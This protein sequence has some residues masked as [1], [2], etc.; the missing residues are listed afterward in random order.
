MQLYD[1]LADWFHL[2]TPPD[3]YGEEAAHYLALVRSV[4]PD[5]HTLLELGSGGGNN[6]SHLKRELACTLSDVSPRMLAVSAALNPECEHVTGDMRVLRLGRTFDAVLLHDAVMYLTSED[7]LRAAMG[8]AYAHTRPGGVA[9]FV[10]DCTL[11][12]FIG[13]DVSTGGR[14][15]PDGRQ[16]RFLEWSHDP[17]PADTTFEVDYL[18]LL[19]EPGRPPQVVH[20]HHVC[21][22]FSERVWLALLEETGF[23]ATVV[24]SEVPEAPQPVFL[25]RRG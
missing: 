18:V 19:R 11:E 25:A 5:A 17:H 21:G 23:A 13:D 9:L 7:D 12:T 20:D 1:E 15:G 24:P 22:L 2:L 16:L 10:P 8:T 6:A 3:D 4:V 14:D